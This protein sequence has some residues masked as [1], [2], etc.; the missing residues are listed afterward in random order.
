MAESTF[1]EVWKVLK[2]VDQSWPELTKFDQDQ[3][4]AKSKIWLTTLWH[5]IEHIKS[6][7]LIH[8]GS[9]MDKKQGSYEQN[10]K[11]WSDTYQNFA[12][13]YWPK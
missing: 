9:K 13:Y 4:W 6:F 1:L 10:R 3:D 2:N 12:K 11:N 7:D 8:Y 5:W